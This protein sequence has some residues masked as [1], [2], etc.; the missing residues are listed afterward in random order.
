MTKKIQSILPVLQCILATALWGSLY[1]CVKIAY[2]EFGIDATSIPSL[3]LFAGIEFSICGMVICAFS[4]FK[5]NGLKQLALPYKKFPFHMLA[6]MLVGLVMHYSFTYIGL[7]MVDSGKTALLKNLAVVLFIC[8]SSI[9]IKDDRF[10]VGKL[11]GAIL[12]IF[13]IIVMNTVSLR[14]SFDLGS[15]LILAASFCTVFSGVLSKKIISELNPVAMIGINQFIGGSI[16][17]ILGLIS[18]GKITI[19]TLNGVLTLAFMCLASL[20]AYC[21][22][23]INVKKNDL[24]KMF[25][26]KFTEPLFATFFSFVIHGENV[27]NIKYLI[28]VLCTIL[29]IKVST[30]ERNER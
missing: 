10:T 23:N 21:I 28:S 24:S 6:I 27:M 1:P 30:Y 15:I 18:G 14:I 17:F 9:F 16:L 8:S 12:G 26:L 3:L 2:S 29:A 19:I 25:I 7:S 22:W 4:L 13:G 11:L 20:S 5:K